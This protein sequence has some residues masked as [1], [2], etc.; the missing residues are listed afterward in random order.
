MIVVEGFS[1]SELD[2]GRLPRILVVPSS[3][4][5]EVD[6]V[7]HGV[8]L[9]VDVVGHLPDRAALSAG[10]QESPSFVDA[11]AL[12]SWCRIGP[13]DHGP[14]VG[15]EGDGKGLGVSAR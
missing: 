12:V 2:V 3:I 4:T 14:E 5:A 15:V 9:Y 7:P 11:V 13:T 1:R 10:V 8:L 6:G